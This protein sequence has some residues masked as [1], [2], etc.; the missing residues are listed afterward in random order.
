MYDLRF[1]EAHQSISLWQKG[2]SADP[3]GPASHAAGYLFA[4]LAR[5]GVLE[6]ELFIN[7][8]RFKERMQLQADPESDHSFMEQIA[9]SHRRSDALPPYQPNHNYSLFAKT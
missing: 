8:N 3:L 2:H 7:D 6:S 1:E 4:E 5:L 9:V